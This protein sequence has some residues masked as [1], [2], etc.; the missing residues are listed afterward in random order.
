MLTVTN[1][2][3]SGNSA[4]TLGGGIWNT[5]GGTLTVTNSTLSGNSA[6]SRGGGGIYNGAAMLAITNSTLSGN[7]AGSGSGGGIV[8]DTGTLLVKNTIVANSPSGGNCFTVSGTIN[9]QGHNLS[10]DTSCSSYFTQTGDLNNTP[11]GLDPSGLQNNGGPTGT[12]ALLP[13]S[14]AVDAIPVSPINYCTAADGI[15]PIATDQRGIARP[16]GSGCDIGAFELVQ[17]VQYVAIVQQ[18]INPDGSSI[19]NAS[20]GVIPVKFSLSLNGTTTCQ[21]PAA[22]IALTR[23]AG[24]TL[25]AIDE[26]IYLASADS[27]SNFRISGCQY[28]YNLA[29]KSL[30]TG[31]YRVDITI[32]GSV[33]GN[34]VFALK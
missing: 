23:T 14:P 17:L 3:L 15:T 9:S 31:V 5:S 2:T 20:R 13:T 8:N 21:L 24:G 26:S 19:F 12:I 30:G 10:D 34:G 18:P 27:G 33:V 7:S 22:T 25:G 32:N 16:Q 11:A 6:G 1:S 29:A 28:V 4:S